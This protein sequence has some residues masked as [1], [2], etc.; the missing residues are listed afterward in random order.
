MIQIFNLNKHSDK[1]GLFAIGIYLQS[2]SLEIDGAVRLILDAIRRDG[3]DALVS[4]ARELDGLDH[5][6]LR[7]PQQD[8]ESRGCH[9]PR[10][11]EGR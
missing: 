3:D 10:G 9:E 4:Y 5:K 8:L 2:A 6:P 1:P 7:V 11:E